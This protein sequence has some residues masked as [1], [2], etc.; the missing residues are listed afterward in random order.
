VIDN[1]DGCAFSTKRISGHNRCLVV[2]KEKAGKV[3]RKRSR[4]AGNCVGGGGLRL[5]DTQLVVTMG[6]GARWLGKLM[7]AVG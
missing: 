4:T 7:I 1:G 2:T 5:R 3:L 6:N